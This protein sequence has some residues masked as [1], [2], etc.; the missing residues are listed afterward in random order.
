MYIIA[1]KESL[2]VFRI[3]FSMFDSTGVLQLIYKGNLKNHELS[4]NTIK[5]SLE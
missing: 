5:D 1:K 2:R 3:E 4:G